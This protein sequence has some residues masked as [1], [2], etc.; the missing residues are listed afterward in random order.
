[1]NDLPIRENTFNQRNLAKENSEH[2]LILRLLSGDMQYIDDIIR[3]GSAGIR[4]KDLYAIIRQREH[5]GNKFAEISSGY[6]QLK[7]Q[8]RQIMR[9]L[10]AAALVNATD[11]LPESLLEGT[12]AAQYL[13]KE[14]DLIPDTIPGVGLADDA[15]LVKRI[16]SRHG[17]DLVRNPLSRSAESK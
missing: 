7:D 6:H 2:D 16:V 15:I 14:E 5:I 3:A 4:A 12:F 9:T 1:M 8:I 11:P 10:E 13:L 17:R